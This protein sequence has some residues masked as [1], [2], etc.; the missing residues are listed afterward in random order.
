MGIL[1][2]FNLLVRLLYTVIHLMKT[3]WL[4]TLIL[5]WIIFFFKYKK[6]YR[7]SAEFLKSKT[8]FIILDWKFETWKTRFMTQIAKDSQESGRFVLWNFYNWYN[9]IKWNSLEDLRLLLYDV[10][11]LGEYQN[12]SDEEL[13]KLYIQD[14]NETYK[15][16]KKQRQYL[17]KK[18]KYIPY[19]GYHNNF[20]ILGDEFQNYMFNRGAMSNFSWD[21]KNLLK[22]FHQVRHFN[23]LLILWTQES[24]ELDVKFRRLSTFYINTG[25]K[26]NWFFYYYNVY[27]FLTD[28]EN[29]LNLEKAHKYTK[30]PVYKINYYEL[31]N[32]L[33]KYIYKINSLNKYHNKLNKIFGSELFWERDIKY[34]FNQLNF[35]TKYNVNPDINTYEAEDLFKKLNK[36]YKDKDKFYLTNLN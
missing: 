30:V 32:L 1:N 25:E 17:R 16:K 13:K 15:E 14:W 6:D 10:W 5:L 12:F 21:N 24:D 8:W 28:K 23:S 18:Y 31:N 34:R 35:H 4:Q 3:Y 22:L 29:N 9:F 33:K 27:Q 19:N 26:L 2:I 11:L 7:N 20:L 36:F